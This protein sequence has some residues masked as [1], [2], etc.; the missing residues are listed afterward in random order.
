MLE[1]FWQI[2]KYSGK[3]QDNIEKQG[4]PKMLPHLS[5]M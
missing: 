4:E 3:V 1:Y 5:G 2:D